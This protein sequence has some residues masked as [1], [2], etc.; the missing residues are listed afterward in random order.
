VPAP[1]EAVAGAAGQDGAGLGVAAGVVVH[2]LSGAP[3]MTAIWEEDEPGVIAGPTGEPAPA[4]LVDEREDW[5]L[6]SD[7]AATCLI[8][9]AQELRVRVNGK[10]RVPMNGAS[11]TISEASARAV[12]LAAVAAAAT[13]LARWYDGDV[14]T[15]RD[16]R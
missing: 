3:V 10:R 6:F 9:A 15:V 8:T 11:Y 4:E 13:D 5:R 2:L 7:L 16:D 1:G 12:A 14:H